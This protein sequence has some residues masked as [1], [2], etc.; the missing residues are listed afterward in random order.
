MNTSYHTDSSKLAD[1]T[2]WQELHASLQDMLAGYVDNELEEDEVLILEAHLAGCKLCRDDLARQFALSQHLRALPLERMSA[3]LHDKLD[4]ITEQPQV[5]SK[6]TQP[7]KASGGSATRWLERQWLKLTFSAGGWATAMA[8]VVA[9]Y[10]QQMPNP[11]HSDIP[12]VADALSQYT[13]AQQNTLPVS[14]KLSEVPASWPGGTLLSSWETTIGGAPAQVYA[15]RSGKDIVFQYRID[16]SVLF[17]NPEVREAIARQGRFTSEKDG[18]EIRALPMK[19]SG[20]LMVGPCRAMPASN[21][22]TI[23]TI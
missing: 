11:P 17:R 7:Q 23:N 1:D 12:M 9:L 18:T 6:V 19:A 4:K 20:L 5:E 2:K 10:M 13:T 22:L 8:L 14:Q 21:E 16:E 3:S 15:M